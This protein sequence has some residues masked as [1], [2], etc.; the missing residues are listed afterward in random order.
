[1]WI[2]DWL[3]TG[4]RGGSPN[5]EPGVLAV[6]GD[7]ES[8][9]RQ[10]GNNVLSVLYAE[11]IRQPYGAQIRLD[12]KV[13]AQLPLPS[14]CVPE[15]IL[16]DQSRLAVRTE[17]KAL[18]LQAVQHRTISEPIAIWVID[19]FGALGQSDFLIGRHIRYGCPK[20]IQQFDGVQP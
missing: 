4:G 18:D 6:L 16:N 19:E 8:V 5:G 20:T 9:C 12:G 14:G 7:E 2:R 3:C 15:R 1:V 11:S 13:K 10:P 17:L